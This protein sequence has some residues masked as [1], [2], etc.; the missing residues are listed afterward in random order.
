MCRQGW[1]S[2]THPFKQVPLFQDL[3]KLPPA[4][5]HSRLA[6][7][8]VRAEMLGQAEALVME[9][10]LQGRMVKMMFS[11]ECST[12]CFFA[13]TV[14]GYIVTA[15]ATLTRPLLRTDMK[16][17]YPI[18]QGDGWDYEPTPDESVHAIAE[19]EGRSAFEVSYDIMMENNGRG[20]IWRGSADVPAWYDDA[21][22]N[23]MHDNMVVSLPDSLV[24]STGCRHAV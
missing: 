20:V 4:E 21:K 9:D 12:P 14:S 11:S 23:L 15:A 13:V 19:R 10:S 22:E 2:R 7:P 18:P 24:C 5:M 3:Q 17:Y 8:S 6:D 1:E 16:F